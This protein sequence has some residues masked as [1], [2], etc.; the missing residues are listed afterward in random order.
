M[1]DSNNWYLYVLECSDESLYT[2]VTTD[3]ERR[4]HEHNN[5]KQGAKYTRSRR[6]VQLVASWSFPSQS[7]SMQA[8]AAFKNLRRPQKVELLE[9]TPDQ[10]LENIA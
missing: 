8:E 7:E 10:L 3:L 4:V 6:P 1:S 9:T 2:G 5:T